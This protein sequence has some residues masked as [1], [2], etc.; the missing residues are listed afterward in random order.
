MEEVKEINDIFINKNLS[1]ILVT[2]FG[3]FNPSVHH[4]STYGFLNFYSIDDIKDVDYT[5]VLCSDRF[6]HFSTKGNKLIIECAPN[7]WTIIIT[8]RLIANVTNSI[9]NKQQLIDFME[10]Y[11][12]FGLTN[13]TDNPTAIGVKAKYNL[14]IKSEVHKIISNYISSGPLGFKNNNSSIIEST[15]KV[16]DSISSIKIKSDPFVATNNSFIDIEADSHN[17]L[18]GHIEYKGEKNITREALVLLGIDLFKK[19][20]NI[21]NDNILSVKN[22]LQ[23]LSDSVQ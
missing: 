2:I 22:A 4:P 17:I 15:N 14:C 21:V 3:D 10:K 12:K 23:L 11:I 8:N 18:P 16:E 13:F 7:M 1:E 20:L 9:R 6:S 5:N 19:S